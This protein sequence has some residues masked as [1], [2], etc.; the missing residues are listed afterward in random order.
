[1]SPIAHHYQHSPIH[2]VRANVVKHSEIHKFRGDCIA[3]RNK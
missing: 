1:M 2:Y 3:H